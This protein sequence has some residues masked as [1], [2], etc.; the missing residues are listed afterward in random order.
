M[1]EGSYVA[2]TLRTPPPALHNDGRLLVEADALA[3]L[4]AARDA[5]AC[6]EP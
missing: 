2:H 5:S 3:S 4:L 6:G 1:H